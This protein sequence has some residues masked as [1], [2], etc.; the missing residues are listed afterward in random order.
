MKE[1]ALFGDSYADSCDKYSRPVTHRGW[2]KQL[3]TMYGNTMDNFAV[4]GSSLEFSVDAFL[5]NHEKYRNI[6]FITTWTHRLRIPVTCKNPVGTL[7]AWI[8][9]HWPGYPQCE[10]IENNF[11][12]ESTED[13][14]A[15]KAMK[16]YF[17]YISTSEYETKYALLRH[18][19]LIE[20]VKKTRHDAIIIPARNYGLIA[21]Y[22]WDLKNISDHECSLLSDGEIYPDIRHNH[23]T[24]VSN[25]WVLDHVLNRLHGNFIDLDFNQIPQ[26]KSRDELVNSL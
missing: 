8:C 11:V 25:K 18:R 20:L 12:I 2:A 24:P 6:V 23:M 1:L 17:V 13:R 10:F 14:Q 15:L 3:M 7:P 21:E 4:G 19:A 5:E 26:F 9:E 16:D 22:K